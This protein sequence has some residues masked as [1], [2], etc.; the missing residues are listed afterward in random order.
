MF[1]ISQANCLLKLKE[2][3][4][5]CMYVCMYVRI[6]YRVNVNDMGSLNNV[7][8]KRLGEHILQKGEWQKCPT[9]ACKVTLPQ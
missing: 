4:R 6:K 1:N 8:K 2:R 7:F 5:I 3:I 9:D